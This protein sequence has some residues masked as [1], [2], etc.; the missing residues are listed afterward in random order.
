M[1]HHPTAHSILSAV[2]PEAAA[3]FNR[4]LHGI[5]IAA[6][7]V[8]FIGLLGL[9]RRL[10]QSLCTRAALVTQAFGLVAA[11]GAAVASG[12]VAS[13]VLL[14]TI[15]AGPSASSSPLLGYTGM[16]NQ[17]FAAI[18]VVTTAISIIL[19]SVAILRGREL[20]KSCGGFGIVVGSAVLL[21]QAI[22]GQHLGIHQ[23]GII[24]LGE[25]IWLV[26]VSLG[27][28]GERRSVAP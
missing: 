9:S 10:G 16:W 11:M 23:F 18:Y 27:L 1:A 12:F 4:I 3:R 2:N 5:A 20:S 28:M 26:W 13:Q 17:G 8:Q 21:W 25:T 19:W 22:G 6:M 14:E 24:L 7:P 15:Q